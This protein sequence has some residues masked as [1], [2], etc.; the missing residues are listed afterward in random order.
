MIVGPPPK[1]S[2]HC[3]AWLSGITSDR[4]ESRDALSGDFT[5]APLAWRATAVTPFEIS[6]PTED[7]R[8]DATPGNIILDGT[9]DV[10]LLNGVRTCL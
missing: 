8:G 9:S 1:P 5:I 7:G 10:V 6:S 2:E 3:E 4:G